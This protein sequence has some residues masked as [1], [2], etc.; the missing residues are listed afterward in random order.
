MRPCLNFQMMK[1]IFFSVKLLTR[2]ENY[3]DLWYRQD[4]ERMY[5]AAL[6]RVAKFLVCNFFT[7]LGDLS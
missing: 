4:E 7:F 3:P 5:N 6:E 1:N 2:I